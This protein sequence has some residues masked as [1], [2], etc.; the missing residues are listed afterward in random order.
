MDELSKKLQ[1]LANE[2]MPEIRTTLE[3]EAENFFKSSF[4]KEGFEDKA[5][6]KWKPVKDKKKKGK[7]LTKTRTLADTLTVKASGNTLVVSSPT[8]Y[9]KIHNEGGKAGKDGS[10]TI[11]KRQFIG[12]SEKLNSI[13]EK[14]ITQIIESKL[15]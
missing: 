11:P 6:T 2:L 3:V 15:D 13:F 5:V 12:E 8:D 7:I 14:E 10:A 9:A 4:D 1:E